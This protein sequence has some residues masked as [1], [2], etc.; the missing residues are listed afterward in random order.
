MVLSFSIIVLQSSWGTGVIASPSSTE[1]GF[2]Q[3]N[4]NTFQSRCLRRSS[5]PRQLSLSALSRPKR[6]AL[7][8]SP[9][10]NPS[11]R[12]RM[13]HAIGAGAPV[14]GLPTATPRRIRTG[15]AWAPTASE[16]EYKD[17]T[18]HLFNAVPPL[19]LPKSSLR[20]LSSAPSSAA[21]DC[22]RP[23]QRLP[24][25]GRWRGCGWCRAECVCCC[26]I[27]SWCGDGYGGGGTCD[28]LRYVVL[29]S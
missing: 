9:N 28:G 24:A 12:S 5:L 19:S 3:T 23:Q 14:I 20:S 6:R 11:P 18:N 4:H 1:N 16:N 10:L 15:T 22:V 17:H 13:G 27:T 8:T 29:S 26:V 21:E 25:S 2:T 7:R